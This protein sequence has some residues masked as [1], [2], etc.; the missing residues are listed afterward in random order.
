MRK[1]PNVTIGT[2]M[3]YRPCY[4]KKTIIKFLGEV[5]DALD[6]LGSNKTILASFRN[7]SLTGVGPRRKKLSIVDKFWLFF[8]VPRLIPKGVAEAMGRWAVAQ[9][10]SYTTKSNLMEA[11]RL[12]DFEE[13]S[14]ELR[15]IDRRLIPMDLRKKVLNR[16]RYELKKWR[17][18]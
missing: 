18:G 14:Y 4:D 12:R 16:L 11:A 7:T 13:L 3:Q 10:P 17:E 8:K 2:V 9:N 15:G 6:V 1:L 5:F